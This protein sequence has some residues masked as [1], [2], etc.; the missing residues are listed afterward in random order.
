[1]QNAESGKKPLTP[2]KPFCCLSDTLPSNMKAYKKRT[3]N[4]PCGTTTKKRISERKMSLELRNKHLIIG[5]EGIHKETFGIAVM[6]Y[7]AFHLYGCYSSTI[8]TTITKL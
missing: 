5:T 1:M 2:A 4:L 7:V 8:A 3:I 6:V